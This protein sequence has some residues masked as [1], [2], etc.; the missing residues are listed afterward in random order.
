MNTKV[1][2]S[3]TF[4]NIVLTF[5]KVAMFSLFFLASLFRINPV[6]AQCTLGCNDN[7]Q[8]SLNNSCQAEVTVA[9]ISPSGGSTCPAGTLKIFIMNPNGSVLATNPFVGASE[10]GKKLTVKV[11]DT[12]SGQSCW[13]SI[14]VEDKLPPSITCS[15]EVIPCSKDWKA[16]GAITAPVAVD[17]C[18]TV[19]V[20]FTE[21]VE[22]FACGVGLYTAVV[23][24]IYTA[25]DA[26]GNKA[27]CTKKISLLRGNMADVVFPKHR[28]DIQA[29]AL[30]CVN[31]N[32]SPS[33]TGEPTIYGY[34]LVMFCDLMTTYTDQVKDLN[35][36]SKY[37]L[38]T[39]VVIDWCTGTANSYIQNIRIL[40]KTPPVITCPANIT[41]GTKATICTADYSIPNYTITDNCSPANKIVKIVTVN[42]NQVTGT[43]TGLPI[44]VHTVTVKAIDDSN[45][46]STCT[47]TVTVI[48]N[49]PPVAVC[50][51]FTKV[52]LGLDGTAEINAITFDDGSVDNC[53]IDRF[54]VARLTTTV[55]FGPKIK[56]DCADVN[57][58]ITVILRVWDKSNN[59]NDCT[60]EVKIE[61]KLNPKITCPPDITLACR[62]DYND[63]TLTGKAVGTD[64]CSVTVKNIDLAQLNNCGVGTVKRTWIATDA[65]GRTA[66]CVQ[67]IYLENSTPFYI[68]SANSQD[69][70]DDVTWPADYLA[71]G[72]GASLLPAVS[73]APILKTDDCDLIAVTYEDTE[74]PTAGGGCLKVLRKWMIVDWCQFKSNVTP[75]VGYWEYVQTITV[76]NNEPPVLNIDCKD[77]TFNTD[78]A[79]CA[80][81]KIDYV[82][83]ASD[84]C[85][86][87]NKLKWTY[88]IDE[89]C[90]GNY[91]RIGNNGNLS[92]TYPIGTHCIYLS[93][94]DGCGN[95][96]SCSYKMTIRDSKK[97]TPV[98][99]H[100]LSTTLMA[101]GMVSVT[102]K[103][104]DGG[105]YDNCTAA[106]DLVFEVKPTTFTCK[107]L[108]A[109]LITFTVTDKAGNKDFCTTYIDIQDNMGMCPGTGST[110]ASIAGAIK[111]SGGDGVENVDLKV[112]GTTSQIMSSKT[113][114]YMIYK[115]IGKK[116][117][118]APEKNDDLMNGVS[119]LDIVKMTKHIL[120][121]DLLP[122]PYS[123]IAADINKNNSISTADI[124][125][126]RKVIL[127]LESK[128]PNGQQ[129]WRFVKSDFIFPNPTN[130]FETAFPEIAKIDLNTNA[131]SD[132]TA[133]K[134]G[135]VNGSAK[136]N[137]TS[138]GSASG[139]GIAGTLT[140][141]ANDMSMEAGKTY[142]VPVTL[143]ATDLAGLQFTMKYDIEKLELTDIQTG[144][145]A[146][147][148]NGNFGVVQNGTITASWNSNHNEAQFANFFTLEFK[149]KTNTTLSEVLAL[150]SSMTNAEAY[151]NDEENLQ[152]ALQ[153]NKNNTMPA[154]EQ[155][156]TLFQNQPNPF[157]EMTE[158][159]FYLPENSPAILTVMDLNGR[160]VRQWK[161]EYSKGYHTL[162][163]NKNELSN[164]ASGIF[165]YQLQTAT[166]TATK[167]MIIVE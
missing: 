9:M 48:D 31:P 128:F 125:A 134:I 22:D 52:S 123:I 103:M 153:F 80:S 149:A 75:K 143:D 119:T 89:N 132:F 33:N 82:I 93:V 29:P 136:A 41:I 42:G 30:D 127:G 8:V 86:P 101:T 26:S 135:D 44:G 165:Y 12:V 72:C 70:N 131:T 35:A 73:G 92:G 27:S 45:N 137:S 66:A 53:E 126:L 77:V 61:D 10:I 155:A 36:G 167:K 87:V 102:A 3:Q 163:M 113:G 105:S 37:I 133:V 49:V 64:N 43:A 117:D 161:N 98:C 139:R 110:K 154:Q 107:E 141:K 71:S 160:I 124:I 28:D 51:E 164:S 83:T 68:N 76:M 145:L 166:Q 67:Y 65:G 129:S 15:D 159:K 94:E 116:Y 38:R 39:W 6:S 109:N 152:V 104:F 23:T 40:D 59:Y 142:K 147:M 108:G 14:L 11:F 18:S 58:T 112:D 118:V 96:R 78:D 19:S 95:I 156:M 16:P 32:T 106:T 162:S 150:N 120:G 13:G 46:S 114:A 2:F 60:V 1:T 85:T 50:D 148:S 57:K 130:P 91:D 21:T 138:A 157:S 140:L 88:K 99:H 100:G 79:N 84:D 81:A 56:F 158:V 17:N 7:V 25:T 121:T 90:N 115:N 54:E 111:T 144:N 55:S 5:P 47:Y 69:P 122:T 24:R 74:L 20:T 63:L 97:P 34:P 151:T 62:T 146:D 4:G